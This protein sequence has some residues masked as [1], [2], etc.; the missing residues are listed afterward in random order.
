[1]AVATSVPPGGTTRNNWA[2]AGTHRITG[3]LRVVTH[4]TAQNSR[5]LG[6]AFTANSGS[7]RRSAKMS[8][9]YPVN[10]TTSASARAWFGKDQESGSDER[11]DDLF[12]LHLKNVYRAR[13]EQAPALLRRHI[14]PHRV[15]WTFVER[16]ARIQNHDQLTIRTN[17]PGDLTWRFDTG[18]EQTSPLFPVR[19]TLSALGRFQITLVAIPPGTT[20]IHFR[21]RCSQPG[22]DGMDPCCRGEWELVA[23]E[24]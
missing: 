21:F 3:K 2:T 8:V 12:R 5:D 4:H 17:C 24:N 18:V 19:G 20:A 23:L 11:F 6:I 16:V 13:G 9:R 10:R 14:V 22:C 15:L 7:A 1:M